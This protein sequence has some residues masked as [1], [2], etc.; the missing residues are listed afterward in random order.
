MQLSG[1]WLYALAFTVK[2]KLKTLNTV[3]IFKKQVNFGFNLKF[4]F[5]HSRIRIFIFNHYKIS[6]F[7]SI[8]CKNIFFLSFSIWNYNFFSSIP[9]ISM[10]QKYFVCALILSLSLSLSIY[11]YIYMNEVLRWEEKKKLT[12]RDKERKIILICIIWDENN[13]RNNNWKKQYK[14]SKTWLL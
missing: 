8:F 5:Y 13:K 11:I 4:Y 2:Y 1:V 7:G 3:L 10:V 12:K 9:L 6:D 14:W